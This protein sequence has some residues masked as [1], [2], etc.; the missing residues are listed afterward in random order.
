[1]TAAAYLDPSVPINQRVGDLLSRMTLEEKAAQ[2]VGVFPMMFM[3]ADGPDPDKMA[4]AIPHGVGHICMGGGLATDPRELALTLNAIQKWLRDHT[5]LK[6]PAMVHNEALSG[7][8]QASAT[9][10][11][12]AIGLASTFAPEL[13]Q[14]MTSV[15]SRE[16]R[17]VGINHVL[18][19]VLDVNRRRQM[20]SSARDIR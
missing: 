2:V 13:I 20:G 7:L 5:R 18:S 10:F 19:P 17:A 8:A 4:E 16:A 3:G 11:P 12:T 15:A 6:I 14:Q 1:M 9:A